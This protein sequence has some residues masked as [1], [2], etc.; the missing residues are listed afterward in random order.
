MASKSIGR[1]SDQVGVKS[2]VPICF[3]I[4]TIR[5]SKFVALKEEIEAEGRYREI[6]DQKIIHFLLLKAKQEVK[7]DPG[8]RKANRA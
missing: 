7:A 1:I 2:T 4:S 3:F 8:N 6:D 5:V